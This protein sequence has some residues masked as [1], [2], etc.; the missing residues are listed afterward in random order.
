MTTMTVQPIDTSEVETLLKSKGP[1]A[2]NNFSQQELTDLGMSEEDI[3]ACRTFNSI[4]SIN[5]MQLL[6]LIVEF[7]AMIIPFIRALHG[8][9]P[10]QMPAEEAAQG[11]APV[12]AVPPYEAEV[13]PADEPPV[14]QPH[15]THHQPHK[16]K[17]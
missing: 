8:T 1:N 6:Q 15:S 4:N 14:V 9:R 16:K 12:E 2:G 3:R 5:W 17:K 11:E 10:H 13:A 7:G